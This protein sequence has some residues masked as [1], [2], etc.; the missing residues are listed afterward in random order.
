MDSGVSTQP[1]V[2]ICPDCRAENI[3]GTDQCIVCGSDL[4]TLKRPS[5]ERSSE[6]KERMISGHLS[7]VAVEEAVSVA[8]GDPVALAVHVMR[9]K[10]HAGLVVRDESDTIIGIVTERDILMKAAGADHDLV[11][12][13]VADI[14]TPDPVMLREDDTL[15]VALHKMSVGGFRHIPFVD[16]DGTTKMISIQDVFRHLARYIPHQ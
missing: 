5:A 8:P 13:T 7:D 2:L 12:L 14:M 9:E 3:E 16:S 15:A 1:N 6:L 11:A 4:R 10:G